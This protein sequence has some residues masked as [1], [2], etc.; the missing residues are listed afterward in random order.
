MIKDSKTVFY[1]GALTLSEKKELHHL[2]ASPYFNKNKNLTRLYTV[3]LKEKQHDPKKIYEK[4]CSQKY[5]EQKLRYL[6]SDLNLLIEQY[7]SL[8]KWDK[9]IFLKKQLLIEGLQEKK[10]FKYIPQHQQS[11]LDAAARIELQDS[12]YLRT[13]LNSEETSYRFASQHDNRSVDSRL[14]KLSD[15]IDTYYFAKKLKYACEMINRSNVLQVNYTISFISEIRA[16]LKTSDFIKVPAVAVYYHILNSLTEPDEEE[17]YRQLK[18]QLF[19]S[20]KMFSNNEL[21]DMF[22]F[23]QNYCIRQLNSGKA[24][25]LEELF[26][27]YDFLLKEK[28]ILAGNVMSQFDFK[29]IVTIALRLQ[30][31]DWVKQF[32]SHYL[33]YIP[34]AERSNAEIYNLARLY[35]STGE[36]KKAVKLM[37]DVEFTDIYYHLDAKVLLVKIYYDTNA[38]ESLVP[39]STSFNNYLKRNKKVSTY[40]RVTYQNFLKIVMRMFNYRM[41]DKGSLDRVHKSIEETK[42]IADI[43]WLKAKLGELE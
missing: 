27:N 8:K 24:K 29:N 26:I 2:I 19:S 43:N 39:L 17:H 5:E 32:I 41:F 11:L 36:L 15:S 34:E 7:F 13:R 25:Y 30:K 16:F 31:Y 35:Y 40:Q 21:R 37:R 14:Q 42:N 38:F 28:I 10:L 18:Q 33:V 20:R 23:A 22:T 6:L 3:L 1:L 9:E 4:V 12:D